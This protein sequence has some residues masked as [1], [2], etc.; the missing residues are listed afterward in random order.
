M[1]TTEAGDADHRDRGE[2]ADG[3]PGRSVVAR[4]RALDRRMQAVIGTG[5]VVAIAVVVSVAVMFF[6]GGD[7]DPPPPAQP[8]EAALKTPKDP[9]GLSD[10]FA[11]SGEQAR[12]SKKELRAIRSTIAGYL[13]A[14]TVA[15][16]QFDPEDDDAESPPPLERFFT[17]RA[18]RRLDG[19][20][21]RALSDDH[22][23]FAKF[24]VSTEKANVDLTALVN[25]DGAQLVVA[26]IKV[27]MRA[28]TGDLEDVE[29]DGEEA[30]AIE[31]KRTGDLVLEPVKTNQ[32]RIGGYE[33][34]VRRD[35]G[36]AV[37]TEEAAL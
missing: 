36:F 27:R 3:R 37:E 7:E 22:L 13:E 5:A 11:V 26:S 2:Q 33:I 8:L 31:I 30:D 34:E 9:T 17:D 21:R 35:F 12:L 14:A 16:L 6:A 20:D 15:P 25:D 10:I 28:R 18:A 1:T 23:P 24:G 29:V 4:L 32:W 19:R